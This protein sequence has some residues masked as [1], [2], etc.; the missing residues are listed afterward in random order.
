MN[1]RNNCGNRS[2]FFL[3]YI[4]APRHIDSEIDSDF[5]GPWVVALNVTI[6]VH[7]CIHCRISKPHEARPLIT[8]YKPSTCLFPI[9]SLQKCMIGPH[10]SFDEGI[11]GPLAANFT[12]ITVLYAFLNAVS[13]PGGNAGSAGGG[14]WTTSRGVGLSA[15][16]E[17]V[18]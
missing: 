10:S 13:D 7:V 17:R 6:Q 9:L 11:P 1:H 4:L 3:F 14:R 8:S 5:D 12:S 2:F 15:E 18:G 16:G